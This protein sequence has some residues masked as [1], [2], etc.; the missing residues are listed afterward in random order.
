[1]STIYDLLTGQGDVFTQKIIN[2]WKYL[3]VGNHIKFLNP[4]S[5]TEELSYRRGDDTEVLRIRITY[6]NA[7][8]SLVDEVR[9]IA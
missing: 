5:T 7:S 1:M 6:T 8:K 2:D 4:S 9:R 3:K